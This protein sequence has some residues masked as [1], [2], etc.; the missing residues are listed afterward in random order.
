MTNLNATSG[1]AP[2]NGLQLYYEINGSGEPLLL[3]HGGVA[4]SDVFAHMVP[5]LAA[6]RQVI[7]VD[8]QG[9]G[10]TRDI[11][12]PLRYEAMGGGVALQTAF[13]HPEVVGKLIVIS[14]TMKRDGSYPE[15]LAIFD[16][17][18][19]NAPQMGKMMQQSP[20]AARYPEADWETIF[21]K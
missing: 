20:L 1:Y 18:R 9:H 4:A 8:L 3:L 5:A 15:V 19:A 13:R 7:T 6:S 14:M 11:D 10:R 2:V 16:Q 17:M 12:R 21:A